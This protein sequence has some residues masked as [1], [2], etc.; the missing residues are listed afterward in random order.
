MAKPSDMPAGLQELLNVFE[1]SRLLE[2]LQEERKTHYEKHSALF[3]K[4]MRIED[5][6]NYLQ[7]GAIARPKTRKPYTRRTDK[8]TLLGNSTVDYPSSGSMR[9]KVKYIL[10][11]QD[12]NGLS[13]KE[14]FELICINDNIKSEPER[15][16]IYGNIS[17]S[18]SSNFK[19]VG[20]VGDSVWYL[21]NKDKN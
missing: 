6:I 5:Q 7:K 9:E 16:K 10:Q 21:K 3:E 8:D 15:K 17:Q 4:A 2:I 11:Q 13:M 12:P 18:L 20:E 14:I 19:R 1:E